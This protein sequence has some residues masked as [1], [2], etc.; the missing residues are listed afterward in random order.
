MLDY[1]FFHDK[2][3][4]RFTDYLQRRAIAYR[5]R[6]DHL[7]MV[8]EVTDELS[9]ETV[10]EFDE[11]YERLLEDTESLLTEEATG[12]EKHAA[13]LNIELGNGKTVQASVDPDILKRVL[14]VITT[15]ELNQL[16][17]AV[18]DSIENPDERPFCR[19]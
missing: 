2:A 4:R 10:D 12:T 19:R 1:I 13:A 6:D 11:F 15:Q 3:L 9:E 5:E 14:S 8:V 18:V 17:E 7:G 16:V